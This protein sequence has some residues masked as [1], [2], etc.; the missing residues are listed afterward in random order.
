MPGPSTTLPGPTEVRLHALGARVEV[1]QQHLGASRAQSERLVRFR[2]DELGDAVGHLVVAAR[3]SLGSRAA[4]D[5]PAVEI[6]RLLAAP[7]GHVAGA[8][9]ARR[10]RI[11]DAAA[12]L[13]GDLVAAFAR[14]GRRF[15]L[16]VLRAVRR[17]QQA[18][19]AAHAELSIAAACRRLE[20]GY[21]GERLVARRREL[22]AQVQALKSQLDARR[23]DLAVHRER[24]AT[25]WRSLDAALREGVEVVGVALER[26]LVPEAPSRARVVARAGKT[27]QGRGRTKRSSE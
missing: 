13:H 23:L 21:H 22:V 12:M 25:L 6:A 15:D 7:V 8:L 17:Y 16:G 2:L 27:K 19:E 9:D 5:G 14:S 10:D 3:D 24:S 20:S 1:L 18:Y 4:L 26:L 11:A